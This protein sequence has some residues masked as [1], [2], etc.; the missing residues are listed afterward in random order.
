MIDV[1]KMDLADFV[2]LYLDYR[3]G[4]EESPLA[5]QRSSG[6]CKYTGDPLRVNAENLPTTL[7]EYLLF[8]A[9]GGVR[10][11][12]MPVRTFNAC[13]S[14][15]AGNEISEYLLPHLK[16]LQRHTII[17]FFGIS[18]VGQYLWEVKISLFHP[19]HIRPEY[20]RVWATK[21]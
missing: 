8:A 2:Q 19:D 16:E 13:K 5:Y 9:H 11:L 15:R 1:E 10:F 6:E 20:K 3:D 17:G 7:R 18:Q 4:L 21:E 12:S 14:A